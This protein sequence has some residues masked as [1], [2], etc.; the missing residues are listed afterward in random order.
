MAQALDPTTGA[1]IDVP[2]ADLG[3]AFKSG[4]VKLLAGQRY[5]VRAPDGSLGHVAAED[6]GKALDAGATFVS[7]DQAAAELNAQ[8]YGGPAGM[9]E[10]GAAGAASQATLGVSDQLLPDAWLKDV[11]KAQQANPISTM[12]GEAGGAI[13]LTALTGGAAGAEELGAAAAA[14]LGATAA[15]DSALA[16]IVA[17]AAAGGARSAF[18]GAQYGVSRAVSDDAFSNHKLTAEQVL[19]TIGSNT[20]W[21]GAIGA[22]L[23]GVVGHL[24]IGSGLTGDATSDATSD[25]AQNVF[26]PTPGAAP[27]FGGN[28]QA[29]TDADIAKVAGNAAG[30]NPPAEGLGGKLRQWYAKLSA[31]AS[32]KDPDAIAR[33]VG[34]DGYANRQALTEADA[35]RDQAM[36]DIRTHGDAVMAASRDV[37][38]IW[39]RGMKRSFIK[40]SLDGV[41]ASEAAKRAKAMSDAV[42]TKLVDMSDRASEFG[43]A[44]P[45]KNTL[46]VANDLSHKLDAAIASGDVSEMYGLTDD[47]KKAIGKPT[48]K[49]AALSGFAQA[50]ELQAQQL[51]ARQRAWKDLYAMVQVGLEDE[52]VWGKMGAAQRDVNKAYMGLIDS[53]RRFNAAL[54]TDIGRSETDPWAKSY[55]ID[56]AKVGGYVRGL[57]QPEKD[58]THQAVKDYLANSKLLADT[59]AKH[60]DL[61]AGKLAQVQKIGESAQAFADTLAKAEKSLTLVNQFEQIRSTASGNGLAFGGVLGTMAH[62]M[63]GGIAGMALGKL[64][65][66]FTQPADTIMQLATVEKLAR[67]SDTRIGRALSGFARGSTQAVR[68]P[69]LGTFAR[70]AAEVRRIA[71]SPDTLAGRIGGNLGDLRLRAPKLA[72]AMTETALAGIALLRDKLPA[73]LPID[74]LDPHAKVPPPPPAQ[75]EQWLRYYHA[76]KDPDGVVED[77]RDGRLSLEGVEVLKAVYPEKYAAIQRATFDQMASGKLKNLDHQRRIG[78]G[79]LL[80]VPTDPTLAPEYIMARQAAYQQV[81]SAAQE[82]APDKGPQARKG[83]PVNLQKGAPQTAVERLEQG[84]SQQGS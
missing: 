83:R 21:G 29:P 51:S 8:K 62:G 5:A 74:P 52:T 4:A 50:D 48:A 6:A 17:R 75:R 31:A 42:I 9:L 45:I 40:D 2:D 54:T 41:D 35:T 14:K 10:A 84:Q 79:I 24:K 78:L 18:E 71:A 49:A 55:G 77:L 30:F 3:A 60:F 80:Q 33:F 37:N 47:L 15:S 63:T 27:S 25:V 64:A 82:P 67:Q 53:R 36:R 16:R 68:P 39:D 59:F 43:G 65:H 28:V 76:V 81:D 69:E 12:L 66:V 58:L 72:D 44:A 70:K 7:K 11:E 26:A 1:V 34:E 57:V 61:P 73:M 22:G 20:L 19:S 56:P 38:E 46:Q 32:G 13:G 23:G